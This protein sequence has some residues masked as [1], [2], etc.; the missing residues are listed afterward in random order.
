MSSESNTWAKY[1][2]NDSADVLEG[3]RNDLDEV[4]GEEGG[5]VRR[6]KV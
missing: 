1:L 2:A 3:E 6:G 5:E 4:V